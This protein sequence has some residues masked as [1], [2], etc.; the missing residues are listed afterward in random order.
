MVDPDTTP[1]HSSRTLLR[2]LWRAYLNRHLWMLLLATF[3]MA[4]EGSMLGLLSWMMKPMFDQVFLA[5][6]QSALWWVGLVI[7][8]IFL[9]RAG[10][11]VVQKVILTRISQQSEADMRGDLLS[12]LMRLDISFHQVNAPGTLM[13]RVIG[14]VSAVSQVWNAIITGAGRDL[15]AV[16]VLFGVAMSVDWRWT[17]V[18]LIGV[19]LLVLPSL[20]AQRFVRRHSRT[21]H[22]IAARQSGRLDEVFHGIVPVKLNRLEKYQSRHYG[23]LNSE[24]VEIEVRTSLGKAAIPGLIDAMSGVSFLGVL[25]YGGGEIISG[26]KTVGEFMAFFTALGF[27]F[28]PLRR[29]GTITGVWEAAAAGIER[30]MELLAREPIYK[31]PENPVAAP[32]GTPAITFEAVDLSYGDAEVLRATS[33]TAKAGKTTALVGPSGAGKSTIFNVLTRLTDPHNG[34]ALIGGV[35]VT[36]IALTDLR[37]LFSVVSQDA[38]LFDETLRENILLGRTNISDVDLKSVLDAAHVTDFLPHLPDGLDTLVGPRGSAL[39]GGQRQR[40]AIAR[41]LLRDTPI[42]LLDEATSALDAQSEA[43]VQAALERLSEGRTTL[44]IAHRLSTIRNADQI[45]VMDAGQVV[46]S[47]TH[48]ELL[49]LDKVYASLHN[50]Q[51]ST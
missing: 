36:D 8:G 47:G 38:A 45:I 17:A 9:V 31:S 32:T 20:V 44:V 18:A 11:S 23:K 2:W 33:F 22:Q 35:P 37:D 12:H 30:V 51:S 13:Q 6:D 25:I 14:D 1:D 46:E 50:M 42:L 49:A 10:A 39:S 29:L 3:F 21:A 4:L 27:A 43:V 16:I 7:L 28:E 48:T 19:P 34:Q 40:V 15:V 24:R 5:G 26:E 41:A